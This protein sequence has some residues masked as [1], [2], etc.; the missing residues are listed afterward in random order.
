MFMTPLSLP[1]L[2]ALVCAL[3]TAAALAACTTDTTDGSDTASAAQTTGCV[4]MGNDGHPAST[5]TDGVARLLAK[6]IEC[7]RD[8]LG[9][10]AAISAEG[11]RSDVAM[12]DNRG[13]HS[14]SGSFSFF[15]VVTGSIAGE[16]VAAG[17][18]FFGHFV[19]ANGA[20]LSLDKQPSAGALMIELVAWDA[21]KGMYNFYELIGDGTR[22]KW[23]YRGD[24]KDIAD[25]VS[26]LHLQ[27]DPQHP[28]F[29][30]RL[31]CS[32]CHVNGGPIMKELDA[33]HNDWWTTA[34]PLP[35]AGRTPDADVA[36]VLVSIADAEVLANAVR[37]GIE[38]LAKS[39]PYASML[40]ARPLPEQL[41]PL[42]CPQEI[43]FASDRLPDDASAPVVVP[44]GF[45]LDPR[46]ATGALSLTV[47]R[48]SY[49]A[50]LVA[51]DSA[52]P[53]TTRRDADHAW[54]GPVKAASDLA[55]AKML[56]DAGLVDDE[57]IADIL[58]VDM[59]NPAL[60]VARCGLLRFVPD[61]AGPGWRDELLQRLA[62]STDP[63]AQ[64]LHANLVDATRTAAAHRARATAISAACQAK[65]SDPAHV[66]SL[67]RLLAQRR[68]EVAANEISKNPRGQ[69]TEP[70]FRIIFPVTSAA[71]QPDHLHLTD[72]CDVDP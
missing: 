41:R 65:V 52:L 54:L 22:G 53:E 30:K 63:A 20:S 28:D 37:A 50:A 33:P 17:E 12:V 72:A 47:P 15:E 14:T 24:S 27:H 16:T 59:T 10:R 26:A 9:F 67:V 66:A 29:G 25:D 43:N 4:A 57:L 62:A 23:H 46:L 58:A 35:F 13:F 6:Q 71:A 2:P 51:N 31:R 19:D 1:A 42:F 64:E 49:A 5:N 61:T 44:A 45:L 68:V 70:G 8:V 69:I 39:L 18:L 3:L 38:H 7:P 36:K 34:R 11:A 40:A 55:H 48:A 60:S 32:G 21:A 56:A